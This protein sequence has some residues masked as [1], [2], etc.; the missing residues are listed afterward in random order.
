MEK[1]LVYSRWQVLNILSADIIR[2]N[3]N[4]V[5]QLCRESG[6]PVVL[7]RRGSGEMVAMDIETYNRKEKQLQDYQD[8]ILSQLFFKN[9]SVTECSAD[10]LANYISGII[11]G[12]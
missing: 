4:E 6:G 1:S 9:G 11:S 12:A 2:K 10:D 3:Y 5:L 7:T 8:I